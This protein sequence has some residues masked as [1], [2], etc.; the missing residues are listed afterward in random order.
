MIQRPIG[1]QK[2]SYNY[3][4]N[5]ISTFYLNKGYMIE[6]THTL[7]YKIIYLDPNLMEILEC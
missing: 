6:V 7:C 5:S 4:L 3:F 1:T 2:M